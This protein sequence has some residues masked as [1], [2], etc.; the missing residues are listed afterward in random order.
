[1]GQTDDAVAAFQYGI[2]VAPDDDMLYLN[3]ARVWVT[4]GD[5][6]RARAVMRQLLERKPGNAIALKGL[7][8]LDTP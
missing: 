1:M 8:A 7:R 4:R 3:L 2:Q 6:D 5:R